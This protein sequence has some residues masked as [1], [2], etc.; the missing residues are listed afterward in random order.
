MISAVTVGTLMEDEKL[1]VEICYEG[2]ER[3]VSVIRAFHTA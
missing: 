3:P 1:L 2:G